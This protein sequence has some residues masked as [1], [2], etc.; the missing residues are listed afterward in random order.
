MTPYRTTFP[1]HIKAFDSVPQRFW[2]T[3]AALIPSL[4]SA[5]FWFRWDAARIVFT[6]VLTGLVTEFLS[7]RLFGKKPAF[8]NGFT[9]LSALLFS[10][11][12]PAGIP[13]WRVILGGFVTVLFG[14]E[15]FGG[16]GA[17]PFH[18]SLL[19]A[20]F[21]WAI[22]PEGMSRTPEPLTGILTNHPLSL[23]GGGLPAPGLFLGHDAGMIG[24]TSAAALLAGGLALIWKKYID[25]RVPAIFLGALFLF[26]RAAGLDP[27]K[28]LLWGGAFFAAF[29]FITDPVT[30]PSTQKGNWLFALGAAVCT[31]FM[32]RGS[33]S[34]GIIFAVLFMNAL[35]PWIDEWVRPKRARASIQ[36][37]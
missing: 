31:V 2:I 1:P 28:N 5:F 14:K 35:T 37:P 27:W 11:L 13:F 23:D 19:G 17:N 7:A 20:G 29:F 36:N 30:T 25:W 6:A 24:E 32:R 22:F 33:P 26:S 9:V 8:Y 4:A 12:M 16:L 21:L 15:I 10:M 18:P 34:G 3:V